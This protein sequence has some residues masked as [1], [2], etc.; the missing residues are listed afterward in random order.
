[1][2]G[3]LAYSGF[4]NFYD[5]YMEGSFAM[6]HKLDFITKGLTFEAQY[7]Y[8]IHAGNDVDRSVPHESE[9]YREYGGYATF[10][11]LD[12]IDVLM[13]GGHYT[14]AYTFPK[15]TTNNTLNN[16]VTNVAPQRKNDAQATLNYARSFGL[17]NIS[18][19]LLIR[20]GVRVYNADIPYATQGESFR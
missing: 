19:L 16:G 13:N 20:Q 11:P 4:H 7:S 6:G 10:Y 5:T 8:D 14:G 9:G 17:H 12:G 2:L 1:M 3:E 15:R 18:A